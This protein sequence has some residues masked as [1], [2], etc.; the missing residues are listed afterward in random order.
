MTR[1]ARGAYLN[2]TGV[3]VNG[4]LR[5]RPRILGYVRIEGAGGFNRNSPSRVV[6]RVFECAAPGVRNGAFYF[7]SP[8]PQ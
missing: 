1:F 5:Q 7:G 6:N 2:T 3:T 8:A 4:S